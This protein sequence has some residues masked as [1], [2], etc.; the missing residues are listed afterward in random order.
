MRKFL[1]TMMCIIMVVCFMPTVAM[2]GESDA[3]ASVNGQLCVNLQEVIEKVSSETNTTGKVQIKL[4]KNI[5][6]PQTLKISEN[7][8]VELDL[9]G[10]GIAA[11]VRIGTELDTKHYY[12]I[13]NY[14][15]I[16]IYDSVGSGE[17]RARG[18]ENLGNGTMT[19]ESGNFYSIDA[20]GGACI[21]NEANLIIKGGIFKTYYEGTP[22]DQQGPACV[23]NQ[24]NLTITG[25][26]FNSVNRRTY[27][28][29]S[30][31]GT[32][33]IDPAEGKE[34]IVSGAHGGLGIDGGIALVNGGFFSSSEYY[35][36]YVSNDGYGIDPMTAAVT[37]NGGTFSGAN[38]SVCIGSDYNDPVN[39]TIEINGGTFNKPLNAQKCTRDG[40]IQVKGGIFSSD[41]KAY[42]PAN[43][44]YYVKN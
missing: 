26:Q 31:D 25:G 4:L 34:V 14:G 2:A 18:I 10:C 11:G 7:M 24:S 15:K 1:I 40:A 19:I 8:D 36:L 41:V 27:A 37:V 44:N 38:Y 6:L 12:A 23:I 17:I 35:G 9:N 22:S 43:S 21:W 32:V 42:V 28:I 29:V 30:D 5:E 20:N 13:D 3:V 39:S 33:K 16:T